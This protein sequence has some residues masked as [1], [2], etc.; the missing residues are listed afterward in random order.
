MTLF[1]TAAAEINVVYHNSVPFKDRRK[2]TN[3]RDAFDILIGIWNDQID[4]YESFFVLFLDRGNRVLGYRC[5]SQGGVSSTVV[6]PKTVFQAALLVNASGVVLSHNHPSGTASPSEADLKITDKL[7]QAGI[8]LE[9]SVLDH[10][11]LAGG[12]FYSFADEGRM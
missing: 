6:D 12:S 7:K 10:L 2:V 11:I 1:N 3:S 8:L 5:I 9:I 4:L